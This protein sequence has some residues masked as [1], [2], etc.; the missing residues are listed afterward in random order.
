[1][2]AIQGVERIYEMKHI[3]RIE[4]ELWY[5]TFKIANNENKDK[6]HVQDFNVKRDIQNKTMQKKM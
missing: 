3:R 1:M 2:K 5:F 6:N 4:N